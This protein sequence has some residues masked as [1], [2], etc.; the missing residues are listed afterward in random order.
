MTPSNWFILLF[1]VVC[2]IFLVIKLISA[3]R[4]RELLKHAGQLLSLLVAVLFSAYYLLSQL[5]NK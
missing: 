1:C 5:I 4:N 2:L 3:S